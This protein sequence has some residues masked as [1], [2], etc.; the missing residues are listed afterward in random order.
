MY[1]F[2]MTDMY[3]SQTGILVDMEYDLVNGNEVFLNLKI[4]NII[5]NVVGKLLENIDPSIK[6]AFAANLLSIL[7]ENK[8]N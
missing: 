3:D 1:K 2:R 8:E 4:F 5:N 6:I 7:Q